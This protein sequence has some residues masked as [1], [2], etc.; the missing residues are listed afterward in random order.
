MINTHTDIPH[1]NVWF[2]QCVRIFKWIKLYRLV[3]ITHVSIWTCNQFL[4]VVAI[5]DRRRITDVTLR[6]ASAVTP[7]AY[8]RNKQ[9]VSHLLTE[10]NTLECMIS[11][12]IHRSHIAN[13]CLSNNWTTDAV[14]H[15]V[16]PSTCSYLL[17]LF[18]AVLS[19]LVLGLFYSKLLF[20]AWIHA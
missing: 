2:V 3:K 6:K 19:S 4:L 17:L 5:L 15:C 1:E 20:F 18:I 11:D 7:F 9:S 16:R 10:S 13:H 12:H 8:H 14:V